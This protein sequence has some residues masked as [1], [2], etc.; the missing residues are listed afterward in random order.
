MGNFKR[1][2]LNKVA[3]SRGW[4]SIGPGTDISVAI[5][6]LLSQSSPKPDLQTLELIEK[7]IA[8]L[9]KPLLS[10]ELHAYFSEQLLEDVFFVLAFSKPQ[11]KEYTRRLR[12]EGSHFLKLNKATQTIE[13]FE[14]VTELLSIT[15]PQKS[16]S[17][18]K[19]FEKA[20]EAVN[21]IFGILGLV[22]LSGESLKKTIRLSN[23]HT[24]IGRKSKEKIRH[25]VDSS[26]RET[27]KA[28]LKLIPDRKRRR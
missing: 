3:K 13:L 7:L 14:T 6:A 26:Q 19:N 18:S 12:V 8:N 27:G 5:S 24:T 23:A 15:N 21:E 11:D 17:K 16:K 28:K 9:T 4:K 25:Y 10:S 22:E 1:G 20:F 2:E